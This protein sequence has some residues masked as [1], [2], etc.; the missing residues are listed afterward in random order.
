MCYLQLIVGPEGESWNKP[1]ESDLLNKGRW[2]GYRNLQASKKMDGF[3]PPPYGDRGSSLQSSLTALTRGV[4]N[5][6]VKWG[7]CALVF[8]G[9]LVNLCG[10]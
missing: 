10:F 2:A 6:V 3:W 8:T 5:A 7:G 9:S 1:A 4:G